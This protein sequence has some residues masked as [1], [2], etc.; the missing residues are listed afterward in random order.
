MTTGSERVP[1]IIAA[2]K[3]AEA[4]KLIASGK[5]PQ[6][7]RVLNEAIYAAPDYPHSYAKRAMV[8]DRLGLAPQAEADRRRAR[9]LAESGGYPGAEVFAQDRKSTRLNS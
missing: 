4:A 7:L 2:A 1:P 3:N 5:F 6:A 8:F 9:D